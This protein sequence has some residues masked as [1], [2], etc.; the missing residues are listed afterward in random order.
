MKIVKNVNIVQFF[1]YFLAF[2]LYVIKKG[3]KKLK[4]IMKH[5]DV[6]V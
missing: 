6:K 5:D 3:K 4:W 2:A 1:P